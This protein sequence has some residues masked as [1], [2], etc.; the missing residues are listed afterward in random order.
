MQ[1]LRNLPRRCAPRWGSALP[2]VRQQAGLRPKPRGGRPLI[3]P[4][5]DAPHVFVASGHYKNGVLLGPITG[6]IVARWIAEGTPG[7]DMSRFVP[8][9]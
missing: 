7:R 2:L 5:T 6:Q 3:G 1:P 4:L 9:R 8:E